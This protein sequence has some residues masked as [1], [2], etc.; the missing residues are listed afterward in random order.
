MPL[1]EGS[2]LETLG[3]EGAW[4]GV[5]DLPITEE[6]PDMTEGVEKSLF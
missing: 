1:E 2:E 5:T 4:D 3:I 6:C